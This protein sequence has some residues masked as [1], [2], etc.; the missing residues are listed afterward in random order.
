VFLSSFPRPNVTDGTEV[1]DSA[2]IR[3]ILADSQAVYRVGALQVLKSET[4]IR[5]VAQVDTLEDLHR[6]L[7]RFVAYPSTPRLSTRTII[8]LEGNLISGMIEAISELLRSAPQVQII[9]QLAQKD[10]FNTV[11][12]YRRGV[13]GIIPRA[14]PA[15]LLVKCV[16]KVAT[17]EIWIDNQ[18]VNWLIEAYRSQDPQLAM[19]SN[20]LRLSPKELSIIACIERGQRNKEIAHDLGTTEQVIKNR[21]SKLYD[22]LGV[23]DRIELALYG[24]RHQLQQKLSY[25]LPLKRTP[26]LEPATR[27][28]HFQR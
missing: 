22:K 13:R 16:R 6:A 14:I 20:Q 5:V 26:L 25:N 21:L 24:Q 7:E 28:D 10:Q 3:V 11:Q 18:S 19:A 8:L 9:A 17:G 23:S 1:T 27:S 15:D 4:D 12:L 2:S